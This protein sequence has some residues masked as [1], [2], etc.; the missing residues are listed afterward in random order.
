MSVVQYDDSDPRP[1]AYAGDSPAAGS[2]P[3]GRSKMASKLCSLITARIV[4]MGWPEGESLGSE[5]DLISQYRVSRSVFR[6]SVRLLEHDGIAVMRRGK[7]GG[8]V[9]RRPD[10]SGAVHAMALAFEYRGVT[11]SQL[12]QARSVVELA[13][14][15]MAAENADEGQIEALREYMAQESEF[16]AEDVYSHG[17]EFHVRVAQMTGNPAIELMVRCL[18]QLTARYSK[19]VESS[20]RAVNLVHSRHVPIAD[21][22]V[23]GDVALARHRMMREF[24]RMVPL[25]RDD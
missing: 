8:L 7:G 17:H 15:Q 12:M 21:A 1:G 9:I 3:H 19:A 14:V 2:I 24:E 13:A 10:E 16:V 25:L 11:V 22:V 23:A 18:A 6:E 5:S 4:E 20:D